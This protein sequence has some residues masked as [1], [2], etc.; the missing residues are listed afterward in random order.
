M[1]RC[2]TLCCVLTA[3]CLAAPLGAVE[4]VVLVEGRMTRVPDAIVEGEDLFIPL[5]RAAEVTGFDV[6]SS[7]ACRG[8]LCFPLKRQGPE[9]VIVERDGKSCLALSR[10]ARQLDQVVAHEPDQNAW[11][12]GEIPE[13]VQAGLL[14]GAAPDFTLPDRTGKPV[15]LAD[16]RGKKVMILSWASW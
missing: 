5:E 11:S 13:A 3:L 2:R 6:K 16:F 14:S 10:W 15:R 8:E 12:F 7:G 4:A 9:A 1:H